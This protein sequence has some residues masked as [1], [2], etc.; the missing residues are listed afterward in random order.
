MF[1]SEKNKFYTEKIML[2]NID[3][4]IVSNNIDVLSL[5]KQN[6]TFTLTQKHKEADNSVCLK[7]KKRLAEK[8]DINNACLDNLAYDL[9]K[10]STR[11]MS[12]RDFKRGEKGNIRFHVY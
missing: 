3:V 9:T 12:E 11:I 10:L 7:P 1:E 5:Q 4:N 2:N 6:R 8:F